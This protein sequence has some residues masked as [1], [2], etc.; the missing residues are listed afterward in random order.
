M[1]ES[2]LMIK[3]HSNVENFINEYINGNINNQYKPYNE[4]CKDFNLK[5]KYFFCDPIHSSKK[6]KVILNHRK[7]ITQKLDVTNK[8]TRKYKKVISL[9]RKKILSLSY[10]SLIDDLKKNK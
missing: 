6:L 2:V 8:T 4:N 7:R 10:Y 1:L 3:G 5:T 9:N